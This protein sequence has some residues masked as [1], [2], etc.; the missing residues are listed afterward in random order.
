[1]RVMVIIKASPSSE[2]G[3]LPSTELLAAMG[4]YNEQL[5]QAGI[6]L[7]GAGL[8]PSSQGVRVQFS[9]TQRM[10]VDGPFAE[11]KEL[12]AGFWMWKVKSMDEAIEWVRK[13]PNPMLEDSEI[14]I[15]PLFE[16]EDFGA[17]FTP[18]LREQEL[19]IVATT[20]GL[21]APSFHDGPPRLLAG[22]NATYDMQTRIAIPQQWEQFVSQAAPLADLHGVDCYGVCWNGQSDCRFDYM[23]AV[24]VAET[25]SLPAGFTTLSLPARRYIVFP[26]RGHVSKIPELVD[27][28]WTQ[29]AP[30]T[31]LKFKH[32]P[33]FERYSVEFNPTTGLGGM[34]LWIPVEL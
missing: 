13:C 23:T 1:M 3:D 32:D 8:K 30:K 11:T 7:D 25:Q 17:E 24:E 34:E 27:K 6:M 21:D 5:A 12:I 28:I 33:W 14:E 29:W 31:G 9:G 19:V 20:L 22:L 18:E 10:V 16:M 2:R 4:A 15:R 26:H